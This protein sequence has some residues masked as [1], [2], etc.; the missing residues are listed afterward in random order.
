MEQDT[1]TYHMVFPPELVEAISSDLAK[2]IGPLLSAH[3]SRE[4]DCGLLDVEALSKYLNVNKTWVYDRVKFNEIPYVKMGKYLRFRKPK[5]D[6]WIEKQ[7]VKP[8]PNTK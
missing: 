7:S 8:I 2:K 1:L 4:Q 3:T 5:I 6:K